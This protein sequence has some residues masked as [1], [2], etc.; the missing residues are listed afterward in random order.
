MNVA[1]AKRRKT[2]VAE[3]GLAVEVDDQG[4]ARPE[5]EVAYVGVAA[6]GDGKARVV[7]VERDDLRIRPGAGEG[8]KS[9]VPASLSVRHITWRCQKISGTSP[10]T[11]MVGG[12]T[13]STSGC[14]AAT[15]RAEIAALRPM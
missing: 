14:V 7:E 1:L 6:S 10:A 15:A 13:R 8:R 3:V 9:A 11:I 5:E 2:L 4:H 12:P